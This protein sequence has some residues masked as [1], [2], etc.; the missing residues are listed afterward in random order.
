MSERAPL[1]PRVEQTPSAVGWMR[2]ATEAPRK[3]SFARGAEPATPPV[4]AQP[5]VR[6]SAAPAGPAAQLLAQVEA[7]IRAEVD[8]ELDAAKEALAAEQERLAEARAQAEAEREALQLEKQRFGAAIAA[9]GE[10]AV[11]AREQLE[12]PTLAIAVGIAEALLEREVQADP[13]LH[14]SLARAALAGLGGGE[15]VELRVSQRTYDA[16][17][18]LE[19]APKLQHA[20]GT[21]AL[22]IDERLDGLGAVAVSD[23]T[24]VDARVSERLAAALD[25]MTHERRTEG[26][27]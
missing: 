17:V 22:V 8:R 12:E 13:T 24:R 7:E 6:P 16:V 10:V 3:V 19:G 25:A 5:S 14:T 18:E 1:F 11:H 27:S 26:D 2:R 15:S 21:M 23:W 9:L 20:G 4:T